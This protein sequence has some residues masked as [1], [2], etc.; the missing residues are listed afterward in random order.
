MNYLFSPRPPP[1]IAAKGKKDG[2][3]ANGDVK[4]LRYKKVL[5]KTFAIAI[6]NCIFLYNYEEIPQ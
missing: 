5:S 2:Q 6:I 4:T 1:L 3:D